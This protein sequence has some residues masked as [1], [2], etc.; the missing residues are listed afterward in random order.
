MLFR[1]D[2]AQYKLSSPRSPAGISTDTSNRANS[3]LVRSV[4]VDV[5]IMSD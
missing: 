5:F 3:E 1:A 4:P 2:A